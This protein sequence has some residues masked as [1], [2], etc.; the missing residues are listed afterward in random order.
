[1]ASEKELIEL[2][3]SIREPT[4]LE[5]LM[6]SAKILQLNPEDKS[7]AKD[8]LVGLLGAGVRLGFIHEYKEHYCDAAHADDM[9][10][11]MG[12]DSQSD[13]DDV[14][15]ESMEGWGDS[16]EDES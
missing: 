8:L 15:S 12:S 10:A 5:K 7:K 1:M 16:G 9:I 11:L 3:K 13:L 14:S 6:K 2:V 4:N